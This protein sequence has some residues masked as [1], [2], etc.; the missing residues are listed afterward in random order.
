MWT[1]SI[2]YCSIEYTKKRKKNVAV[3]QN[4]LNVVKHQMEFGLKNG[5]YDK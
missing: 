2:D 1:F 3:I 4:W 5:A